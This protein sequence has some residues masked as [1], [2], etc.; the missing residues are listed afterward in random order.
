[1]QGSS[2]EKTSNSSYSL[3]PKS[4]DKML[5]EVVRKKSKLKTSINNLK[6]KTNNFIDHTITITVLG[7]ITI[8]ALLADDIRQLAANKTTDIVFD[9]FTFIVFGIFIIEI[10]LSVWAKPNYFLGYIF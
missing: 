4:S 1:M 6:Q 2:I 3:M 5:K 7:V 8:Y 10:I 9:V